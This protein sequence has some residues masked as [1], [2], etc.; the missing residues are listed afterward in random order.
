MHAYISKEAGECDEPMLSVRKIGDREFWRFLVPISGEWQ[1][2]L[3][4]FF[5]VDG[6]GDTKYGIEITRPKE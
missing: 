2:G 4:A 5:S 3:K 1:T 6:T